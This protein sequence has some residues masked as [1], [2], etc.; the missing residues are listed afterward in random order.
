[1]IFA[2]NASH[3]TCPSRRSIIVKT[4]NCLVCHDHFHFGRNCVMKREKVVIVMMLFMS[5]AMWAVDG[6]MCAFHGKCDWCILWCICLAGLPPI[7][8]VFFLV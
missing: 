2:S 1:M 8:A 4:F 6:I 5:I 7:F 3:M